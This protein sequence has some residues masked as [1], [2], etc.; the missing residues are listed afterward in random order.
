MERNKFFD[1]VNE[2][3]ALGLGWITGVLLLPKV[4]FPSRIIALI[5]VLLLIANRFYQI[6]L[7]HNHNLKGG[8]KK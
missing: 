7:N 5:F 2:H 6:N 4:S 1:F 3:Q 8:K